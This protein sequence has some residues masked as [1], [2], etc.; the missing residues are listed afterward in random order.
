MPFS[1]KTKTSCASDFDPISISPL[2]GCDAGSLSFSISLSFHHTSSVSA[3]GR[4]QRSLNLESSAVATFSEDRFVFSFHLL[5]SSVNVALK[6]TIKAGSTSETSIVHMRWCHRAGHVF[7]TTKECLYKH[8]RPVITLF[9]HKSDR[10]DRG[11]IG[12]GES[13]FLHGSSSV[14]NCARLSWS[15]EVSMAKLWFLLCL[16]WVCVALDLFYHLIWRVKFQ[17]VGRSQMCDSS[18]CPCEAS[19]T[20]SSALCAVQGLKCP[21]I[22]RH[23]DKALSNPQSWRATVISPCD[24]GLMLIW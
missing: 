16:Q 10:I 23:L 24:T 7:A 18:S 5:R 19:W 3:L 22:L 21:A 9:I 20:F 13:S 8:I 12:A 15:A 6:Y 1:F 14:S 4:H 11:T 2:E 17:P